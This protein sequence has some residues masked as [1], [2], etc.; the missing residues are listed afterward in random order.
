MASTPWAQAPAEDGAELR[1]GLVVGHEDL[2]TIYLDHDEHAGARSGG[3]AF[4]W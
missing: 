4:S 1:I 2:C 3:G